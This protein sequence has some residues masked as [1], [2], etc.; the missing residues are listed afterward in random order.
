MRQKLIDLS[1]KAHRE[2]FSQFST[3]DIDLLES[4]NCG[5]MADHN[6]FKQEI[7]DIAGAL[8]NRKLKNTPHLYH[9]FVN[10]Y[11]DLVPEHIRAQA[12]RDLL[13][14]DRYYRAWFCNRQMFIFHYLVAKDNFVK[15]MRRS[16]HL[17]WSSLL[18]VHTPDSCYEFKNKVFHVTDEEFEKLAVQHWSKPQRGCRCS[19]FNTTTGKASNYINLKAN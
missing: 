7:L 14:D 9:Q 11:L 6:F 3:E 2:W 1:R 16:S 19:L 5:C 17:L 15:G 12:D 18:D 13:I 10:R 4:I 8:D